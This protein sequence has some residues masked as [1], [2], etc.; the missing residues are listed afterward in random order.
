MS[1]RQQFEGW[2]LYDNEA[3][4]LDCGHH[5]L[6]AK[7][8]QINEQPW[9][10]WL[11]KHE[12]HTTF[13]IPASQL[14]RLGESLVHNANIKTEYAAS[15]GYTCSVASLATSSSLLAGQESNSLSNA[16]NKYLDELVSARI[17]A[18]TSPTAGRLELHAV[19]A[20]D[21][22]PT[23]PDVFDGTDSA[24]TITS[25]DIKGAICSLIGSVGTD[26]TTGRVYEF[27]PLG[28]ASLWNALPPAHVLFVTHSMVAALDST[29][30]NHFLKHTPVY[31][32]SI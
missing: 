4:C 18:G 10:D 15:A 30:G 21:D 24:E 29:A 1:A 25:A 13:I 31:A 23:W 27:K 5:H 11:H 12:G 9:L 7:A 8:E 2:G 22:T 19:G 6:I 32:T 28:I 17:K 3:I 16:S 14:G 20:L 26:T